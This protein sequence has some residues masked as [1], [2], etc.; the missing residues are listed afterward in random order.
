MSREHDS[1]GR[2][3]T[4]RVS[5]I[6]IQMRIFQKQCHQIRLETL[7][8]DVKRSVASLLESESEMK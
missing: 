2:K 5:N 6:D 3:T 7:T 4:D 8:S 1:S